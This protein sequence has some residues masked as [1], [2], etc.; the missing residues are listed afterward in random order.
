L[1]STLIVYMIVTYKRTKCHGGVMPCVNLEI[2]GLGRELLFEV[3]DSHI[4]LVVLNRPEARNAINVALTE[5]LAR[6]VRTIDSD[7]T[8]RVAILA[9]SSERAFCAGADLGDIANGRG[10]LLVTADGGF[11]GFVNAQ[12]EKP[13]IAAVDGFAVGGGCE[14]ALACDMIVAGTDASF[15]LPE[16][17]RGLMAGAGGVYRMVRA[18]P[19]NVALELVATGNP[20]RAER[21]QALGL[22]NY[23]IPRA[24]LRETALELARSIA[25]NAPM[26]VRES[27]KVARRAFDCSDKELRV[28]SDAGYAVVMASAD[29]QEGA[30]AFLE[31][32]EPRWI[33]K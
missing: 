18:V 8:I 12:R 15:G 2:A 7:P 4:A 1:I 31:K 17:K 30:R 13:W 33:G 27:L 5:A 28:Q 20:I 23:V 25:A 21:A 24:K 16:V 3:I 14:L 6:I 9:S 19:R 32:R 22:V 10:P 26:A 11:A 29:A